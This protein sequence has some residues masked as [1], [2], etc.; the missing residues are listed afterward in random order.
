MCGSMQFPLNSR[1]G[2][3]ETSSN[4][5]LTVPQLEWCLGE[6]LDG[7]LNQFP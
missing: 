3:E 6:R 5:I 4:V 1:L 7:R 2:T